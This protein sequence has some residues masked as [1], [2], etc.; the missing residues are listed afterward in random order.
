MFKWERKLTDAVSREKDWLF[1]AAVLLIGVLVRITGFSFRSGDMYYYLEPWFET[2]RAGGFSSLSS[3]VGNYNLLYQTIIAFM[4]KI[5]VKAIYQYKILSLIGDIYLSFSVARLCCVIRGKPLFRPFFNTVFAVTFLLPTV[6]VNSAFWGQCDSLYAAFAVAALAYAY[7][8]RGIP[9]FL[10]FGLALGFKLQAIFLLPF[11]IYLYFDSRKFSVLHFL[12]SVA[13]FWGTGLVCFLCGQN[14]LAP[15]TV[16]FE[17][18]GQ[19]KEMYMNFP[20]V[21]M[22]FGNNYTFRS[23]A[24]GLTLA[25][26]GVVLY[27]ILSRRLTLEKPESWLA[28][29]C[30][31]VWTCVLFL[32]AMHD[33]YGYLLD[34]LLIALAAIR[35]RYV[36]FAVAAA[37]TS[38]AAYAPFL[39]GSGYALTV[40]HAVFYTAAYAWFTAAWVRAA[41]RS[42]TEPPAGRDLPAEDRQAG[43]DPAQ[44]APGD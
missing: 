34:V 6:V 25:A 9:A 24:L 42:D 37:L 11:L 7:R 32:P 44:T 39:N 31:S 27:W 35:P 43:S 13:C 15:F 14:L 30:W 23:V 2:I 22:L 3:R 1:P 38:L 40:W 17:Q 41:F 4:T 12:L 16:Y 28:A 29:A 19:Y 8:N 20:S 33:R 26:L 21:W 18:T 10:L 5:P 36:K